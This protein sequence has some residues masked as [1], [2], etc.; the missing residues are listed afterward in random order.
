MHKTLELVDNIRYN[1]NHTVNNAFF[2]HSLM[3]TVFLPAG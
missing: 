1:S 3:I 2:I